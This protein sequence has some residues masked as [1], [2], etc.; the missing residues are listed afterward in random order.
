MAK[1]DIVIR[2]AQAENEYLEMLSL[3]KEL[4]EDVKNGK[5]P[6]DYYNE[7]VSLLGDEI[8]R[9]RTQYLFW[10]EAIFELNKPNRKNKKLDRNTQ[11][12]YDTITTATKKAILDDDFS[13]LDT[14]KQLIKEG[15]VINEK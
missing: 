14:L 7:K 10:A 5:I 12:W 6:N 13:P 4:D 3:I 2:Y 8:E 15:K 1:K 9:I 11:S